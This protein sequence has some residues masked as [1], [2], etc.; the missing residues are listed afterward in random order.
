MTTSVTTSPPREVAARWLEKDARRCRQSSTARLA[1]Q[2]VVLGEGRHP[3]DGLVMWDVEHAGTL[4]RHISG[5]AW[6][7]CYVVA[8]SRRTFGGVVREVLVFGHHEDA[9]PRFGAKL[10][11]ARVLGDDERDRYGARFGVVAEGAPLGELVLHCFNADSERRWC[12]AFGGN[13]PAPAPAPRRTRGPDDARIIG[14]VGAQ[15]SE[16][17]VVESVEVADKVWVPALSDSGAW[18]CRRDERRL[19]S[20]RFAAVV[21]K[22]LTRKRRRLEKRFRWS[23]SGSSSSSPPEMP[24]SLARPLFCRVALLDEADVVLED[25]CSEPSLSTAV[26]LET[27]FPVVSSL[28]KL[29]IEVR[30]VPRALETRSSKNA[31]A[32]GP[33]KASRVVPLH[34]LTIRDAQRVLRPVRKRLNNALAL[35]R[36]H[37]TV[38]DDP[39]CALADK[40]YHVYDEFHALKPDGR[41]GFAATAEEDAPRFDKAP[42]GWAWY[43][44]GGGGRGKQHPAAAAIVLCRLAYSRNLAALASSEPRH[45]LPGPEAP[46]YS[47]VIGYLSR[48]AAVVERHNRFWRRVDD[49][50]LWRFPE[51]SA[52]AW[53]LAVLSAVLLGGDRA[54]ALVPFCLLA[55]L[56]VTF[57]GRVREEHARRIIM[58]TFPLAPL[59]QKS[60]AAENDADDPRDEP[61]EYRRAA[62]L[63]VAVLRARNLVAGNALQNKS[64]PY[65]RLTYGYARA[66]RPLAVG[67]T[68]AVSRSLDPIW[69][70][71]RFPPPPREEAPARCVEPRRR[72][73]SRTTRLRATAK[74]LRRIFGLRDAKT[75]VSQIEFEAPWLRPDGGFYARAFRIPV[76]WPIDERGVLLRDF[77][78]CD[79]R[80]RVEVCDALKIETGDVPGMVDQLLG[81]AVVPVNSVPHGAPWIPS[82]ADADGWLRLDGADAKADADGEPYGEPYGAVQIHCALELPPDE[83]ADKFRR[84]GRSAWAQMLT[85]ERLLEVPARS[86]P[87]RRLGIITRVAR[88]YRAAVLVQHRLRRAV[89]LAEQLTGLVTWAQPYHTLPIFGGLCLAFAVLVFFP[90]RRVLVCCVSL[91]FLYGLAKTKRNAANGLPQPWE[92][93]CRDLPAY[94]RRLYNLLESLPCVPDVEAALDDQKVAYLDDFHR[95]CDRSE[96]L[97]AWAGTV[98]IA[99]LDANARWI[100]RYA[101]V[102]DYG[103]I[104]WRSREDAV[105]GFSHKETIPLPSDLTVRQLRA[106]VLSLEGC[107]LRGRASRRATTRETLLISAANTLAALELKLAL[108]R[109]AAVDRAVDIVAPSKLPPSRRLIG[110]RPQL[111]GNVLGHH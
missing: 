72:S 36:L 63:R 66:L 92:R 19:S 99:R 43:G 6:V 88:T 93:A 110:R 40:R 33:A 17:Q 89:R 49:L 35:A 55:C 22:A 108:Q 11:V 91:A 37:K 18:R 70:E 29:L 46:D 71:L 95:R 47:K 38:V 104:L 76:L 69:T 9:T 26:D 30:L 96:L 54:F 80:L 84:P 16:L 100:R 94:K 59:D 51:R 74:A 15:V 48:F 58:P 75:V 107:V 20:R 101:A 34:E 27:R 7:R 1:A 67:R 12:E 42:R 105:N 78:A 109:E 87:A 13:A 41:G 65:V 102:R 57:L 39:D 56:C 45:D 3:E 52:A 44:L 68:P 31:F 85:L 21:E 98:W 50:L 4:F 73:S 90:T 14:E 103:L 32:V 111:S 8:R 82:A 25:Y 77:G 106:G 24:R 10:S 5:V 97:A 28:A 79:G 2:V 81:Q 64:D 60:S 53:A 83:A 86:D 61:R 62:F 23:S